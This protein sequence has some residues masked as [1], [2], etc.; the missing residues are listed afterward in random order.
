M[1]QFRRDFR[2]QKTRVPGLSCGVVCVI[3]HLAVSVEH[4]LVTDGRTDKRRQ[5]ISALASVAPVETVLVFNKAR[6]DGVAVASAVP[7]SNHL[8]VVPD[9]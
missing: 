4:R 7:Y 9:R 8:Y 2:R 5:L 6:D 1:F 3:L